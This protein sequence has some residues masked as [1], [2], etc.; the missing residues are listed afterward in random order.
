[1]IGHIYILFACCADGVKNFSELFEW[2]CHSQYTWEDDS[3]SCNVSFLDTFFKYGFEYQGTSSRLVLT[4]RTERCLLGLAQTAKG[5][6][7]GMCVGS[8]V[9]FFAVKKKRAASTWLR[10]SMGAKISTLKKKVYPCK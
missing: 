9:S 1:M 2:R 10:F 5:N 8:V 4:P 7:M 6:S 3:Q